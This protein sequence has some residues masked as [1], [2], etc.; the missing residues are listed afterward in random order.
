[1]L[2]LR[3]SWRV[4]SASHSS[5]TLSVSWF[6]STFHISTLA[7]RKLTAKTSPTPGS[8]G[9]LSSL[10]PSCALNLS[11]RSLLS[12]VAKRKPHFGL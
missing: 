10:T 3:A 1:M 7:L 5:L 4:V 11:P 2:G 12:P 6:I 9:L 8:S